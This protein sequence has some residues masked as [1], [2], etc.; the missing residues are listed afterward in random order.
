MQLMLWLR[1][2]SIFSVLKS[3][4]SSQLVPHLSLDSG[5]SVLAVWTDTSSFPAESFAVKQLHQKM[6]SDEICSV[7]PE[8]SSDN[9][10]WSPSWVAKPQEG[11]LAR[12]LSFF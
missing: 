2:H 9:L 7:P 4:V 11:G 12:F 5:V 8:T 3:R 6:V 10:L 1:E